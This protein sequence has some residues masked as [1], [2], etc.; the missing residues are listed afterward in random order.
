MMLSATWKD[1]FT[2][3]VAANEMGNQNTAVYTTAWAMVV[4]PATKLSTLTSDPDMILFA[5]D[6]ESTMIT[7]HSFTN[8]GGSLLRPS[9]KV[10]CL[11]GSGH[12]GVPLIVDE[13]SA[14]GECTFKAPSVDLIIAGKTPSDLKGIAD[15]TTTVQGDHYDYEGCNTFL[16]APWLSNAILSSASNDPFELILVAITAAKKFDEEHDADPTYLITAD[17]HLRDFVVWAWGVKK[18]KVPPTSYRL[19][20]TDTQLQSFQSDRHN[21]CIANANNNTNMGTPPGAPLPPPGPAPTFAPPGTPTATDAVLQQLTASISRQTDEAKAQNEILNRQLE[22]NIDK[23]EKKKDRF[24]KLHSSTKQLILFASAE[25]ATDVPIEANE[26]CKRF[27][28]AETVGVAEQELNLQF[29]KLGLQDAAFSTGLTQALYLGKFQWADKSTPSNFSPFSFFEV[30]PLQ[31]ADQQNRHL[32]LHLVETQ[33]KGKTLDEIKAGNKQEVKAPTT[34]TEMHH[35]LEFFAGACAIFFGPNSIPC[36]AI[37]ALLTLV[38]D[39]RINLKAKEADKTFMS[40]FLFAVDTRFQLWLDECMTK[41]DRT[42]VDDGILNFTV[43]MDTVRFSTFFINL[44]A[45]FVTPKDKETT[46]SPSGGGKPAPNNKRAAAEENG[47][48]E[49]ESPSK[50]KKKGKSYKNNSQPDAF[51]TQPGET[52]ATHYANKCFNERVDWNGTCKMCPRWFIRGDCFKNCVNIASHVAE[53]DIPTAKFTA[54]QQFIRNCR[55]APSPSNANNTS[56]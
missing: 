48:H 44:P 7:L 33:G 3:L 26:E 47:E 27:I 25:E 51:K 24:K 21:K 29:K 11:T 35:Q 20:L 49:D 5:A 6:T 14:T 31:A 50:K 43:F 23:E 4:P 36:T 46:T 22:H 34:Y 53:A 38:E 12:T 54:F 28:N 37:M 2:S 15:P 45:T 30:E 16:P 56:D 32:I 42:H 10:V 40:Q 39:N 9:N 41:P 55:N 18:G 13:K 17:D 52:W 8:L 19:S 1:Y